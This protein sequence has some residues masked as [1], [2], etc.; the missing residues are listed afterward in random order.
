[1]LAYNF[2]TDESDDTKM[3]A[4]YATCLAEVKNA[5][6]EKRTKVHKLVKQIIISALTDFDHPG[7]RTKLIEMAENLIT[8]AS[9]TVDMNLDNLD[10]E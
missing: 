2:R 4:R 1:M 9:G 7:G 5:T 3:D 8:T 6:K 10:I